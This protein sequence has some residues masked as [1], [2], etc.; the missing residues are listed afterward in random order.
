MNDPIYLSPSYKRAGMVTSRAV[1]PAVTLCVHRAQAEGYGLLEGEPIHTLS[2]SSIGNMAKVRNEMLE[3]GFSKSDRVVMFDD[4]VSEFRYIEQVR[5]WKMEPEE[6]GEFIIKGFLVAE[7]L[8]VKLW[9][10]NLQADPKFYREYSPFSF[11]SPILGTFSCHI[12]NDLRYDERLG[13]NE[14]YDLFLQHIYRYHKVLRFNKYHYMAR[15][16]MGKGGC[17]AYRVLEEEKNQAQIMIN[18][19]GRDVVSYDFR[20]STNP[21]IRVPYRGI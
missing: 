7:E 1:S 14:D 11:L 17:G 18:K 4:D 15:H 9:G 19:W 8:G 3:Y 2:N 12:E 16:L 6:V 5:P 10:V 20:R 13:F 21:I